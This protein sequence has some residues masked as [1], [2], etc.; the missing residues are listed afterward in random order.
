MAWF[1]IKKILR[2]S[3]TQRKLLDIINKFC[4]GA[5]F[6][7]NIK[8]PIWIYYTC[9]EESE[10]KIKKTISLIIAS[11]VKHLGINFTKKLQYFCIESYNIFVERNQ[12]RPKST[13]IYHM[14]MDQKF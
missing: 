7:I 11:K 5:G 8:Q 12:R 9:S 10:N 13:E 6:K 14:F 2:Y 4:K 3:Q 1:S